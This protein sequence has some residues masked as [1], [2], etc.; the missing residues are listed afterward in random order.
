MHFRALLLFPLVCLFAGSLSA[1]DPFVGKWMFNQ[2]RSKITGAR[3]VIEDLGDNKYKFSYG[4]DSWILVLDGSDQPSKWGGTRSMKA[5][6]ENTWVSTNN[7]DGQ[8]LSKTEISLSADGKTKTH[9]WESY[10]ADGSKT[11]GVS[12]QKRVSGAKG[13]AGTWES[14]TNKSD[15]PFEFDIE[16]YGE[17][18]LSFIVPAE[19]DRQDMKFDGQ[20]YPDTG[21]HASPGA[22]SAAKRVDERTIDWTDK[23]KDEVTD[24]EKLTVSVDGKTLTMVV[25]FPGEKVPQT[26]VY[27]RK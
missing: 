21:P 18:G 10:L 24:H 9:H 15:S 12:E 7:K 25:H 26:W 22:T 17:H 11:S 20:Y 13:L 27:D 3:E 8:L 23:L 19:K 16:P 1:A 6:G 5:T 2:S 4:T 14:T